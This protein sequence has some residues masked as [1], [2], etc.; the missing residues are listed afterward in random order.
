MESGLPWTIQR[1][2]QFHDFILSGAR[3]MSRLPLVP[4]PKDFRCQPIDGVEVAGRLVDLALGP[5]AG[6][7]PDIGGPEVSTWADLVRQYLRATKR[8]RTVVEVWMP[9]MK[10][11]RAG[12]LLVD[13]N[14]GGAA[15][16]YGK[17]TWEEFIQ[18]RLA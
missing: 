11:I 10:E 6:R 18:R 12:G 3:N 15:N 8:K 7:V 1:A 9:R 13:G 14:S 16:A 4:V 2:T 5:P 17:T